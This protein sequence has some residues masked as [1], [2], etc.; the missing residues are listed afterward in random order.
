MR[1]MF[2]FMAVLL[3][4]SVSVLSFSGCFILLGAAAGAGGYAYASG[5][6]E[7][8]YD[9]PMDQLQN[10]TQQGFKDLK[11]VL[12]SEDTDRLSAKYRATLADGNAVKVD[13]KALTEKTSKIRIRVG[14]IG[15]K[16]K[17]EMILNAIENYL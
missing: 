1:K 8:G 17:S 5:V 13:L 6:L 3:F 14:L 9:I 16:A 11:L 7:K 4:L 10:A 15:D 2:L 12:E